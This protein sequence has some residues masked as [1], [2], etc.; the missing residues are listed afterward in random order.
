MLDTFGEG[1]LAIVSDSYDLFNMLENILGGEF[2]D[3][4]GNKNAY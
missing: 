2:K 3:K 4:V 1:M